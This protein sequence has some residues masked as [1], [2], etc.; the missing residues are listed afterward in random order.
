MKCNFF[1]VF[2]TVSVRLKLFRVDFDGWIW[3]LYEW[4]EFPTEIT[5]FPAQV[6]FGRWFSGDRLYGQSVYPQLFNES[7]NSEYQTVLQG[8][9]SVLV[10]VCL[11][12][13]TICKA[14]WLVGCEWKKSLNGLQTHHRIKVSEKHRQKFKHLD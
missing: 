14:Q 9:A 8:V 13:V 2:I 7:T 11:L 1:S 4:N 10:F 6:L 3:T 12:C 5:N